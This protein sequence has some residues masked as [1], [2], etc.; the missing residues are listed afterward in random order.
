MA[1]S[2]VKNWPA[3]AGDVVSI[4]ELVKS[5]GEGHGNQL[6]Y[7]YMGNPMD[8]GACWATVHGTAE[9]LDMI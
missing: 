4:P 5:P 9:V 3:D 6:Q 1:A 2:L 8:R 7:S